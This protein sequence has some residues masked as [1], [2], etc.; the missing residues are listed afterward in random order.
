MC[1][2]FLKLLLLMHYK[3]TT[4]V[5]TNP[6]KKAASIAITEAAFYIL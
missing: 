4:F 6:E 5:D 2:I 1:I 3:Y